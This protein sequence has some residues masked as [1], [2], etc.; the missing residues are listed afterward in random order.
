[1]F[2]GFIGAAATAKGHRKGE[3]AAVLEEAAD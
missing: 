2:A 3:N 1:L